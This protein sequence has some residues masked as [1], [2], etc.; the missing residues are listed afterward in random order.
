M[1]LGA[2]FELV[3]TSGVSGSVYLDP[4]ELQVLF[5][6]AGYVEILE[7]ISYYSAEVDDLLENQAEITLEVQEYIKAATAC[8]LSRIFD[9]NGGLGGG[10]GMVRLGDLQIQGGRGSNGAPTSGN[11][12]TWC[13]LAAA[14]RSEMLRGQK[15]TGMRAVVRGSKYRNPMPMRHLRNAEWHGFHNWEWTAGEGM[16][17]PWPPICEEPT[18]CEEP[19]PTSGV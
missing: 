18:F 5:P 4:A 9:Y 12:A 19:W 7:F 1:S 11:A 15:R 3:F 6:E 13:Q 8:A 17:P 14:L 10:D 16:E 2:D